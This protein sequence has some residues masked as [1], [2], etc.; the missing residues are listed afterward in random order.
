M[1]WPAVA[2]IVSLIAAL[3]TFATLFALLVT[4]RLTV[5]TGWGRRLRPLGPQ[6]LV[7]AASRE[8]VFDL[9]AV[10]YVSARPPRALREK[11]QVIDRGQGM[12]LAA[13]RTSSTRFTTITLETVTFERP[14]RVGF[15]LVR[16]PVPHVRERFVL[17]ELDG[18]TSTE[19]LYDGELG[20]DGWAVGAAWGRI[21]A[22]R[23]ESTV[24][25]SLAALRSAAEAQSERRRRPNG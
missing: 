12:V 3:A 19:L 7:I 16:G 8:R 6:T 9:I 13:H 14:E 21:V 4:G 22:A 11:V 24:A 15:H 10:P 20:T 1:T 23:W 25:A 5:D 2:L 17:R 18:G